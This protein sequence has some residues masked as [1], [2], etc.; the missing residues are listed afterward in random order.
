MCSVCVASVSGGRRYH[1]PPLMHLP[2][3]S[4]VCASVHAFLREAH[5]K[6]PVRVLISRKP[7]CHGF[8]SSAAA[9]DHQ[10]SLCLHVESC[11]CLRVCFDTSCLQPREDPDPCRNQ[12]VSDTEEP[13]VAFRKHPRNSNN[14]PHCDKVFAPGST[15]QSDSQ[16]P[17]GALHLVFPRY[18]TY[19][20]QNALCVLR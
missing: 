3:F 11:L 4:C 5:E 9:Q 15:Y 14:K 1:T 13:I 16:D 10:L 20:P 7:S 2:E 17:Q 12:P 19:P 6:Y 18:A 8:P